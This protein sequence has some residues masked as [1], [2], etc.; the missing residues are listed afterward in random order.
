ME[1]YDYLFKIVIIGESG[2]GKT[3]MLTKLTRDKFSPESAATIGV[4]FATKSYQ[5]EESS[6]KAQIWDTAG[7]ERYMAITAAYFRGSY[8][9]II[10]YDIT[11]R[12]SFKN[13]IT[14]WYTQLN[15]SLSKEISV[16]LIG[17]KKDLAAERQV[18]EKE[19]KNCAASNNMMFIETSALSGENIPKAFERLMREVYEKNKIKKEVLESSSEESVIKTEKLEEGKNKK[20]SKLKYL[21]C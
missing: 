10:V 17:N 20:K 16:M 6:V 3:N 7:Q 19:A 4:E 11:S 1:N 18:T 15:E 9:A 14:S 12:D 13:A 2:V 5:F 8:G 21:C